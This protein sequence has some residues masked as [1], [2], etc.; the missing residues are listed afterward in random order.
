MRPKLD[1]VSLRVVSGYIRRRYSCLWIDTTFERGQKGYPLKVTVE[2]LTTTP[3]LIVK[4][5]S[6]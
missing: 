1:S 5:R 6:L 2:S 4:E 3:F